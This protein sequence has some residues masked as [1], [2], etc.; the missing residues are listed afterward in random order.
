MAMMKEKLKIYLDTTVPSAY[1]DDR[2]PDRQRLTQSFWN[3]RMKAFDPHISEIVSKEIRD[4]P[5]PKKRKRMEALVASI[6]TLDLIPEARELAKEYLKYGIFQEKY[7]ADAN[8]VAVAVLNGIGYLLSW[9]FRHLV[10]VK[11]RREVNLVNALHGFEPI[12]IISPPE[13]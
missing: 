4:T 8:H 5:D 12:E 7:L 3:F 13:L 10:K 6:A 11:T 9:N 2:A 1:F